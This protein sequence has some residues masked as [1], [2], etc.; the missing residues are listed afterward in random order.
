MSNMLSGKGGFFSVDHPARNSGHTTEPTIKGEGCIVCHM[1]TPPSG[2]M[3]GGHSWKMTWDDHGTETDFIDACTSCH[4]GATD[5]DIDG[6]ETETLALL[7]S[8]KTR[9]MDAGLIGSDNLLISS[10]YFK[11]Q[12][13]QAVWNYLMVLEDRSNGL[14]NSRYAQ[15]ML[16]SALDFVPAVPAKARL[17]SR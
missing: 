11:Q 5:F 2:G 3:A 16:N 10:H 4:S 8:V 14:H 12:E 1:H 7:D 9:L 6:A 17:A 13:A 15:A